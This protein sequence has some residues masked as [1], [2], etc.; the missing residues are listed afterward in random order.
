[1][2]EVLTNHV[3]FG[4]SV[5][6]NRLAAPPTPRLS[7]HTVDMMPPVRSVTPN[8]V[9]FGRRNT[10]AINPRMLPMPAVTSGLPKQPLLGV[11]ERADLP[12]L[13]GTRNKFF[14]KSPDQLRE[15]SRLA[16][17][18][19]FGVYWANRDM[20]RHLNATPGDVTTKRNDASLENILYGN[21]A[22]AV[23]PAPRTPDLLQTKT[24]PSTA[25]GVKRNAKLRKVELVI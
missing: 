22:S 11:I 14:V 25:P 16:M 20:Q 13:R 2:L 9:A 4:G 18:S 24:N 17:N 19:K 3:R 23:S 7:V 6:S 12:A 5:T 1:M 21:S 15:S 10:I 8:V